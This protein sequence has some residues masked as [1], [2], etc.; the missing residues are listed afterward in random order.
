MAISALAGLGVSLILW[1]QVESWKLVAIMLAGIALAMHV[2]P[3]IP[4]PLLD[5]L[6][7][8]WLSGYTESEKIQI[9]FNHLIPREIKSTGLEEQSVRFTKEAVRKVIRDYTRESGLRSL[10]RQIAA[11]CRKIALRR[12]NHKDSELAAVV[13]SGSHA[14]VTD[15]EPWSERVAA[16][17][18]DPELTL[19]WYETSVEIRTG[20]MDWT[21]G[22]SQTIPFPTKLATRADLGR[23]NARRAAVLY[24]RTV[25][26][27][28]TEVVKSA[29]EI[30][31]L[32]EAAAV[33]E[34]VGP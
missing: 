4:G 18:P 1:W 11:L 9:A 13:L 27:V 30:G 24:E 2:D 12:L 19:G 25:R 8:L 33:T 20:P 29:F 21:V 5:R 7:I 28:L 15:H 26:D 16:W 17:L 3:S 10:Q 22:I 34:E 6:E 31:Y 23:A 32:D 14:M